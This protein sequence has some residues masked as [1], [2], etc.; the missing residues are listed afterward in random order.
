[1]SLDEK[2]GQMTQV[3]MLALKDKSDVQKYFLRVRVRA[4]GSSDPKDGNYSGSVA[5]RSGR[6]S[7]RSLKKHD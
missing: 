4:A 2:I 3:D 7:R 5:P 6:I 1:M